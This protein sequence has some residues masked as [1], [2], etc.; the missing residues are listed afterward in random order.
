MGTDEE[1]KIPKVRKIFLGLVR[2]HVR[3]QI[4]VCR[5]RVLERIFQS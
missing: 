4:A 3:D 1:E 5:E 2:E